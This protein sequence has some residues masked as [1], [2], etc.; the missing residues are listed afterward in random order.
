M[1]TPL[2][3]LIIF[4]YGVT[5]FAATWP[6]FIWSPDANPVTESI[7]AGIL[8]LSPTVAPT[9]RYA[10][11]FLSSLQI[12]GWIA[13]IYILVLLLR[14]VILRDRLEAPKE[15]IDRIYRRYGNHSL[16]AFAIQPDK[17][18]LLVA[19]GEGLVA[20]SSKRA[21]AL[22]C[23]DPIAPPALFAEAVRGY[24]DHCQRHGLTPCVYMASEDRL[25]VYHSLRLQ[26]F[27]VA[28]EAIIDLSAFVPGLASPY[29]ESV[30]RYDRSRSADPLIDEQLE[31]VSE[32]WLEV[33]RLG[34]MGFTTGRFS[35]ESISEGP[36]FILGNRHYV[37]AF[38]GWLLYK[39]SRGAVLD[40]VRQRRDASPE[41]IHVLLVQ[42]MTMLKL[43]FD[44]ASVPTTL[45][46][47]HQVEAFNP[48]WKSQ[49]LVHPR[50]AS[51]SRITRA[52]SAVQKR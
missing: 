41:I 22:A 16:A 50:G 3:L 17:H 24:I 6:Q 52:L 35:L 40:I 10:S 20:Y 7:R 11:L 27:K 37:Y 46:D 23:G 21:V 48:R 4:L 28:E 30:H 8:I 13:R 31:E 26:S 18:H 33:R 47:L 29:T 51:L 1:A 34:E 32:D 14:P 43:E 19:K 5:G 9:T 25:P 15:H 44:E 38:C 12:A 39:N 45:L 42:A 49:H 2:L 36:V